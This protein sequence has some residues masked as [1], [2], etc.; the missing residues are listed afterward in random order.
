MKEGEKKGNKKDS[1]EEEKR[2]GEWVL[3]LK[4]QTKIGLLRQCLKQQLVGL[5]ENPQINKLGDQILVQESIVPR[6]RCYNNI[7]TQ[8]A[9]LWKVK[10][11][12][13]TGQ[14]N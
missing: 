1:K 10:Q 11:H 12:H 7:L 8:V 9:S 6:F 3:G 13:I 5:W 2:E 14:P 4:P